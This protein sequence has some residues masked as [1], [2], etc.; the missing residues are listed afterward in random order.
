MMNASREAKQ[1]LNTS[2][3]EWQRLRPRL[4]ANG[5]AEFIALREGFRKGTPSSQ[6]ITHP[7]KVSGLY[8]L[9]AALI[10]QQATITSTDL[11]KGTFYI[12]PSQQSEQ[13]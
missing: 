10:N 7:E 1:I 4:K 9:I 5:E 8:A 3:A 11:A 12:P 6:Q 2:N 13:P